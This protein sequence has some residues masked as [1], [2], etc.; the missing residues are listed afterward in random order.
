MRS[1]KNKLEKENE[2]SIRRS[3]SRG[4]HRPFDGTYDA[5]SVAVIDDLQSKVAKLTH[6]CDQL[7]SQLN[8]A[9]INESKYKQQIRD[10][11]NLANDILVLRAERDACKRTAEDLHEML[12]V[13]LV[14]IAAL[15]V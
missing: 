11:V 2:S 7:S 6:D 3:W 10:G 8:E 5:A 13:H 12:G 1:D 15:Q 4:G 14:Q 9:L